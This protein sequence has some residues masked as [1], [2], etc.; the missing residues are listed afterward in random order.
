MQSLL[1][2]R[3]RRACLASTG[4]EDLPPPCALAGSVSRFVADMPFFLC[5]RREKVDQLASRFFFPLGVTGIGEASPPLFPPPE[6]ASV[7]PIALSYIKSS[8]FTTIGGAT[9]FVKLDQ[10][11]LPSSLLEET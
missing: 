8:P 11:P 2:V 10:L 9:F 1:A 5:P 7:F 4:C 3:H 6:T